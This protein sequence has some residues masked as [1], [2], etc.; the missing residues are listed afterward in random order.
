MSFQNTNSSLNSLFSGMN[1]NESAKQARL[2]REWRKGANQRKID[3]ERLRQEQE[4][5]TSRRN[6]E[7]FD[8]IF[9][10]TQDHFKGRFNFSPE[11]LDHVKSK[12][13]GSEEDLARYLQARREEFSS[14][15]PSHVS[16]NDFTNHIMRQARLQGLDS[17]F[18]AINRNITSLYGP[19]KDNELI[20]I[21]LEAEPKSSSLLAAHT[22]LA[23]KSSSGSSSPK[24]GDFI[25][26]DKYVQ[27][28]IDNLYPKMGS[29]GW[30]GGLKESI[31]G[32]NKLYRDA[33]NNFTVRATAQGVE[34][35]YVIA[36]LRSVID[37]NSTP[38]DLAKATGD[39]VGHIVNIAKSIKGQGS[40][41]GGGSSYSQSDI[42]NIFAESERALAKRRA[43]IL[44]PSTSVLT[45]QQRISLLLD[46][47]KL[48]EFNLSLAASVGKNQGKGTP[49]RRNNTP[50]NTEEQGDIEEIIEQELS[51][52][53]LA[54]FDRA[55]N[56]NFI[57]AIEDP[58]QY[59][60]VSGSGSGRNGG[61]RRNL[62]EEL[63]LVPR[64]EFDS[65]EEYLRQVENGKRR[66]TG[67]IERESGY[68][69]LSE[70]YV[71]RRL[72]E[73][74]QAINNPSN[75]K[76]RRDLEKNKQ[77]LELLL[78]ELEE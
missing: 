53:P 43:E 36:A 40:G 12:V 78:K 41:G 46:P 76:E 42:N 1:A 13:T 23:K 54:D 64:K 31:T 15:L 65:V 7:L 16:R 8:S 74:L 59:R 75:R 38:F 63:S 50:K 21:M 4:A 49:P 47:D 20:K 61:S 67:N 62:V 72:T 70:Q 48:A 68:D 60:S 71:G 33:L 24:V 6:Q 52:T 35:P 44:S 29:K 58:I 37:N 22:G 55:T 39:Q 14:R 25:K 30:F 27:E 51:K 18:D 26:S 69:E 57:N 11:T 3:L 17:K 9:R 32:D 45:P 77:L 73:L 5:D 28:M 66:G 10:G 2:D 34:A 19:Q 56:L